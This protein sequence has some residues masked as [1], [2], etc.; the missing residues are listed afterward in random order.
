MFIQVHNK[1]QIDD[2]WQHEI[3][4]PACKQNYYQNISAE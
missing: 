2:W 1:I 4:F 3:F